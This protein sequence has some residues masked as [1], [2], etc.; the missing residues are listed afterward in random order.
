[1][2]AFLTTEAEVRQDEE[3]EGK[4]RTEPTTEEEGPTQLLQKTH[5]QLCTLRHFDLGCE[6]QGEQRESA[7]EGPRCSPGVVL[8]L[9]VHRGREDERETVVVGS[10]AQCVCQSGVDHFNIHYIRSAW[11]VFF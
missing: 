7:V 1:M 10:V 5:N 6:R 4:Q 11:V 3:E 2:S 9:S 8:T